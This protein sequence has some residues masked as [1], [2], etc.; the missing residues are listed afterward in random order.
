MVSLSFLLKNQSTRDLVPIYRRSVPIVIL[1]TV[2][3]ITLILYALISYERKT[4]KI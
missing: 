4:N 1:Q 3:I 2:H